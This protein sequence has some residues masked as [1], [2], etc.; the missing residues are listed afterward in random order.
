M[1]EI[2][3]MFQELRAQ[4]EGET[5]AQTDRYRETDIERDRQRERDRFA[6]GRLEAGDRADVP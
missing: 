1:L 6:A 5:G 3:Q 4:G 2:Q